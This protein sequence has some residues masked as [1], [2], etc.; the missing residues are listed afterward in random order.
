[1]RELRRLSIFLGFAVALLAASSFAREH[2]W[3]LRA[4]ATV[5]GFVGGESHDTYVVHAVAGQTLSI[6]ISWKP[7][8]DPDLG[9]NHAEFWVGTLPDFNADGLVK[10]GQESNDGKNWTATIPKTSNYFVYVVAHPTAHYTLR[11]RNK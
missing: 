4:P 3:T 8:H 1:M 2:P 11:F 5:H 7:E 10:F 6:S 9:D